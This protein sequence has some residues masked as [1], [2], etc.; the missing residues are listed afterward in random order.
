[1][2]LRILIVVF[3]MA[4]APVTA[5]AQRVTEVPDGDTIVV[6]GIGKIHLI[7]IKSADERLLQFGGSEAQPRT[8]PGAPS[9]PAV[10]GAINLSR[11]RPSRDFLRELA[12]GRTVR[13][14]YD[15]GDKSSRDRRAYVFLENG[16]LVNAEMLKA[17]RATVDETRPF[18]RQE[19]FKRLEAEARSNAVGIWIR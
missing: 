14:E 6:E 13:I 15:S 5:S 4:F 7:G 19:E 17:G 1:M 18:R 16:T 3:V 8:R 10:G 11:E 12:L 2:L 9:T